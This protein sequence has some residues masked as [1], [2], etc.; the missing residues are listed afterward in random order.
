MEKYR[1]ILLKLSG[2]ALNNRQGDDKH[3]EVLERLVQEI[4][5]L[6]DLGVQLGI[7]IGGG[8]IVRGATLNV[9]GLRRITGDQMGMLATVINA[10][11]LRDALINVGV[12]SRVMSPIPIGSMVEYYD[13]NKAERHFKKKR[14]V[15]FSSGTGSPFFST[16]SAACLRGIEI[17]VD[18]ILK[19]TKV[20]GVYDK[21]P[22][23]YTNAVLFSQLTYNQIL[24]KKLKVMDLTAICLI[25][26]HNLPLRVFNMNNA[27]DLQRIIE[28]ES[29]GTLISGG[30]PI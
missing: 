27:G 8:N 23:K 28:G 25:Q 16:D 11:A 29:V 7:V 13:V 24:E 14:T 18:L 2:E 3:F 26:E 22:I 15:I 19:A 30:E 20:D 6:V 9:K 21:D 10:L 5:V 17:G 1:R 12:D 4:K